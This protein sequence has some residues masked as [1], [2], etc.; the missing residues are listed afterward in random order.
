MTVAVTVIDDGRPQYLRQTVESIKKYV[1]PYDTMILIE[2][3]G[4]TTYNAVLEGAYPEFDEQVYHFTRRGLAG[5]VRSAW[6]TAMKYD[7]DFVWHHEGDFTVN[8][9]VSLTDLEWMLLTHPQLAQV[10]LKRQ[11]VND[12]E[13]AAGGFIQT[14]PHEYHQCDGYVEHQRL[15]TFNPCLIPRE[16][17]EVCL[18]TPRDGL[19]RGFTQTLLDH[20]YSFGI[21]GT[22][23][24]PPRVTHIGTSRALGWTV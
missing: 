16:V 24:D 8:E 7:V 19:E 21:F 5:A 13:S 17:V 9:P 10:S 14:S 18:G 12:A 23:D 3:S 22:V 6:E 20:G 11:A 1:A 4:E 2:D 15:F